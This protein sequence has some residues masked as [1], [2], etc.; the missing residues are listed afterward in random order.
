MQTEQERIVRVIAEQ[1]GL[2]ESMVTPD[3]HLVDHLN[4]DSLDAIELM[5]ALEDE[6]GLEIPDEDVSEIKTVGEISTYIIGRLDNRAS[7]RAYGETR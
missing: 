3:Q 7:Q 1:L 4:A 2:E 6:F 5:M